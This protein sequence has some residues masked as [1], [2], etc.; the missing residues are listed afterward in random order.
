VD[1]TAYIKTGRGDLL[2]A[3][4][5]GGGWGYQAGGMA[6]VEPTALAL[7]AL[8][9]GPEKTVSDALAMLHGC[10]HQDGSLG[11]FPGDPDPSWS[12]S[13]AVLALAHHGHQDPAQAGA[14]WLTQNQ[15]PSASAS[16]ETLQEI[17]R[18]L[19]I[20]FQ[21]PGWAWYGGTSPWVEPT[22]LACLALRILPSEESQKQI[23]QGL[24]YLKDRRMPESSAWN[25]GNPYAFGKPLYPLPIPS[26]KALLA[27][28]LCGPPLVPE[29]RMSSVQTLVRLLRDNPSGKAHAWA[30]LALSALDRPKLAQLFAER[31]LPSTEG[32]PLT[33]GGGDLL[34]LRIL[35]MLRITGEGPRIFLPGKE[36]PHAP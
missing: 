13:L 36:A 21:I 24:A 17:R 25:Y 32:P 27:L 30:S 11:S 9:T 2:R 3:A 6:F 1:F 14:R 20:N 7:L 34:G 19:H 28:E 15:A 5:P 18:L 8:P 35:A 31:S 23:T 10:Q 12:T 22:A 33:K 26:A 4:S 29:E 16:P